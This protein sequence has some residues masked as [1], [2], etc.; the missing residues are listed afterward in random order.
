MS[1]AATCTTW[2]ENV[3]I[4]CRCRACSGAAILYSPRPGIGTWGT[5]ATWNRSLFAASTKSRS[6]RSGDMTKTEESGLDARWC[7]SRFIVRDTPSTW[8]HTEAKMTTRR[9]PG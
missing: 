4:W 3:S 7:A 5:S 8:V 1:G 2:G 9:S 6:A